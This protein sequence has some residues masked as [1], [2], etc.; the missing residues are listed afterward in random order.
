MTSSE[1]NMSGKTKQQEKT[2]VRRREDPRTLDGECSATRCGREMAWGAGRGGASGGAPSISM[3]SRF[4][5]STRPT[6]TTNNTRS[7]HPVSTH[8]P[9][10]NTRSAHTVST[11]VFSFRTC[12]PEN[13]LDLGRHVP[14]SASLSSH[15]PRELSAPALYA[16]PNEYSPLLLLRRLFVAAS[17][18]S[19]GVVAPVAAAAAA[20][21]REGNRLVSDMPDSR[22][23][24]AAWSLLRFRSGDGG[25][26]P[27][28]SWPPLV[29]RFA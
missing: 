10:K 9:V 3:S 4:T 20:A 26:T 27:L 28:A 29:L 11:D 2:M 15:L 23:R 13:V 14:T 18:V 17:G 22:S 24:Y 19:K 8:F 7:A 6:H 16:A 5:G 1:S 25:A 12:I 21:C